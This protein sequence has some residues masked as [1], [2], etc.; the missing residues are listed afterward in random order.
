MKV[1]CESEACLIER[2]A[3]ASEAAS[4]A[5]ALRHSAITGQAGAVSTRHFDEIPEDL[6]DVNVDILVDEF[7]PQVQPEGH[8]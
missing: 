5:L 4:E 2:P 7:R 6:T 1:L 3:A 8:T